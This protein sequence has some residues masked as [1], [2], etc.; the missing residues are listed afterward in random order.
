MGDQEAEDGAF[1][2]G[3]FAALVLGPADLAAGQ[4]DDGPAQAGA[5]HLQRPAERPPQHGL[6]AG[7]QFAGGERLDDVIVG[8]HLQTADAVVLAAAGRKDDDR[9]RRPGA[10]HL[11]QHFQPVAPRQ[12]QIEQHQIDADAHGLFE[13][14]DAVAGLGRLVAGGAQGVAHAAADGLFVLDHHYAGRVH[15][16]PSI[17]R[18]LIRRFGRRFRLC[19]NG[20]TCIHSKRG[21]A[22]EV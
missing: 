6:D 18:T 14:A 22:R 21:A 2:L 10:A 9:Q 4:V 3:Q 19:E 7:Q 1:R 16:S 15:R 13:A 17:S 20:R 11:G 8:A 12:H 5:L